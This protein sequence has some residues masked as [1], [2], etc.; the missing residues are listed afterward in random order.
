MPLRL[1]VFAADRKEFFYPVMTFQVESGVLSGFTNAYLMLIA[2]I[3]FCLSSVHLKREGHKTALEQT[4]FQDIR[5]TKGP[6]N[7]R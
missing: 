1:E 6:S 7:P 3:L 5:M 2:A 4:D